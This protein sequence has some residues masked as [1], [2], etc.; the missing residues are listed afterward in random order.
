MTDTAAATPGL[1]LVMVPIV[2]IHTARLGSRHTIQ[3]QAIEVLLNSTT[4]SCDNCGI[5]ISRARETGALGNL[6]LEIDKA[7]AIKDLLD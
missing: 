3:A 2:L 6:T 5:A 7:L 1:V 4:D